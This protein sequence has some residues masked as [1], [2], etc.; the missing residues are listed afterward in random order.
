MKR[1][2][3]QQAIAEDEII[4]AD[5]SGLTPAEVFLT[6]AEPPRCTG[7][8]ERTNVLTV[9]LLPSHIVGKVRV[10]GSEKLHGLQGGTVHLHACRRNP[11]LTKKECQVKSPFSRTAGNIKAT[12]GVAGS[13][14]VLSQ[15]CTNKS[16][17][18]RIAVKPSAMAARKKGRKDKA[19]TEG[20]VCREGSQKCSRIGVAK[21]RAEQCL[22]IEPVCRSMKGMRRQNLLD[23]ECKGKK[24]IERSRNLGHR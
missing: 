24:A 12:H 2:S 11:L 9:S 14:P 21:S 1:G 7:G 20:F 8:K 3:T 16:R 5:R 17:L 18:F 22:A 23:T 13:R 10:C 6:E 15:P 4:S 19:A